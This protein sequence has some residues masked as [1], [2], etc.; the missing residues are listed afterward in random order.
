MTLKELQGAQKE[1][2]AIASVLRDSHSRRTEVQWIEIHV[3][4]LAAGTTRVYL[5][6]F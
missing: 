5:Q 4:E 1:A 6:A 3:L 2:K